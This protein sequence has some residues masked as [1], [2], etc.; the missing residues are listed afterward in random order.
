MQKKREAIGLGLKGS[1][2]EIPPP[3]CASEAAILCGCLDVMASLAQR[4]PVGSIPKQILVTTMRF[5]V[6]NHSS[7]YYLAALLMLGAKWMLAKEAFARL[8]PGIAVASLAACTA[9][10]ISCLTLLLCMLWTSPASIVD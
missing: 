2:I 9:L 7:C 6:V 10:C 1:E 8:L 5:D 3:L 4:L